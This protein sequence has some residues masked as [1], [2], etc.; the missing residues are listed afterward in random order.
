VRKESLKGSGGFTHNDFYDIRL[1]MPPAHERSEIIVFIQSAAVNLDQAGRAAERECSLLHEYRT[2]LIAD[3]VTGKLDVREA[4][5]RLPDEGDADGEIG[6]DLLED[7]EP[8][9]DAELD[10]EAEEIEA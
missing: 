8:G 3:V 4:A 7:N 1:P 10:A 6:D 5:A 2:R 9:D